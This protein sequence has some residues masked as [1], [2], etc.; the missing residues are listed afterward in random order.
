[1]TIIQKISEII[2]KSESLRIFLKAKAA[3]FNLL[4]LGSIIF[5]FVLIFTIFFSY[6]SKI[7]EKNASN[8]KVVSE[9]N[10][11]SKLK[12]YLISKINSPYEEINYTIKKN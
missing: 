12:N 5:S 2:K 7:A 1:M 6:S 10:E 3:N 9:N 11:F 8:L 4:I